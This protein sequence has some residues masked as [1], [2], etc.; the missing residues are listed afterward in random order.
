MREIADLGQEFFRWEM[1]IAVAGSII[2]IDPFDQPDVEAS[3]VKTRDLT[4]EY[5]KTHHFP[6]EEPM[7]RDN[8]VAV[9]ADPRNAAEL[10]RQNTLAGYL[11]RHFERVH[12]GDYV[13]LPALCRSATPRMKRL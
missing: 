6:E 7:F 3:K 1:A 13:A 10:G 2:G 11:K 9:Y 8:G 4:D 5:E 12:A